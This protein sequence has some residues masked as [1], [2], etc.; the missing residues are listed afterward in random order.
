MFAF[1]GFEGFADVL[2]VH[3]VD[4]FEEWDEADEVFVANLT[5]PWLHKN[6]IFGLV[7]DVGGFSVNYYDF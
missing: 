4:I 5:F 6:G 7:F 1:E 3:G 2:V